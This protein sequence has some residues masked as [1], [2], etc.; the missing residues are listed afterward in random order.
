LEIP[1]ENNFGIGLYSKVPLKNIQVKYFAQYHQFPAILAEA[2]WKRHS[3]N[4]LTVHPIPPL[5]GFAIRNEQLQAVAEEREKWGKSLIVMGDLNTSQWSY[6]FQKLLKET[7][8]RDTQLGHGVQLSWPAYSQW[9]KIPI[10][11][12]LVSGDWQVEDRRLGLNVG[13][14]HLPVIVDLSN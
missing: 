10:D 4:L 3:F 7:Q 14:D 8:L 12:V 6:Y 9:I 11:H 1:Q 5:S 13:S 2:R